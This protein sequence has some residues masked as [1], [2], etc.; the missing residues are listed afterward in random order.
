MMIKKGFNSIVVYLD[1]FLI[2]GRTFGECLEAYTT[3]IKLLRSLGFWISWSKVCDPT[4]KL[5]FLGITIDTVRG[6]LSLEDC[7]VKELCD[8]ISEFKTKKRASKRKLESLAGKLAWIAA[9]GSLVTGKMITSGFLMNTSMSKSSPLC[10][11]QL[12]AGAVL[13]LAIK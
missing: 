11:L 8:I 13:G 5:T 3:L 9:T 6:T 7:K 2:A 12:C 10:V 4:T 1:D